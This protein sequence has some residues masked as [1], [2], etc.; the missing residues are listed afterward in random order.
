MGGCQASTLVLGYGSIVVN[1]SYLVPG[2]ARPGYLR[3]SIHAAH[4]NIF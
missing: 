2:V 1:G 3:V 4:E